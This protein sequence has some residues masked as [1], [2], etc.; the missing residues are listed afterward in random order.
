MLEMNKSLVSRRKMGLLNSLW[1]ALSQ[2]LFLVDLDSP[3]IS[4]HL[5]QTCKSLT[6]QISFPSSTHLFQLS[7]PL[8]QP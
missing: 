8:G 2:L 7:S 3:A 4:T 6:I 1:H 5:H